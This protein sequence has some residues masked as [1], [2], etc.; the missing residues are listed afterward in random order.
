MSIAGG[1]VFTAALLDKDEETGLMLLRIAEG[2]HGPR[3]LEVCENGART[4]G[5]VVCNQVSTRRRQSRS[6]P[7]PA[8]SHGSKIDEE[9]PSIVHNALFNTAAAGTPLFKPLL[10]DGR[11]QRAAKRGVFVENH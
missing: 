2:G 1:Q 8:R 10:P 11:R 6:R 7:L 9:I 5:A 4:R 3:R